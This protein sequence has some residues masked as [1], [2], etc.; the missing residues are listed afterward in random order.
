MLVRALH[1]A[2]TWVGADEILAEAANEFPSA[3]ERLNHIGVAYRE[4]C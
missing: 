2:L 4:S 1:D 3:R